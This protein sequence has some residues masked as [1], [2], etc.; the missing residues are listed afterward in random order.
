MDNADTFSFVF[1]ILKDLNKSYFEDIRNTLGLGVLG[2]G[3]IVT[4]DKSRSFLATSDYIRIPAISTL[5]IILL[6][7]TV[8][9]VTDYFTIVEH[10]KYLVAIDEVHSRYADVYTIKAW[11][12][13]INLVSIAAIFGLLMLLIQR[14]K[15]DIKPL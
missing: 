1:E 12:V 11:H 15:Y 13:A 2:I 4:S 3:W 10:F 7:N 6:M 5:A 9:F 8:V 14:T